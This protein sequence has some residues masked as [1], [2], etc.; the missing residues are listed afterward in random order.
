MSTNTNT[1][2]AAGDKRP[3]ELRCQ[4]ASRTA[5]VDA[6]K[7][8][9]LQQNKSLQQDTTRSG[10]DSVVLGCT[11]RLGKNSNGTCPVF[12][13]ISQSKVSNS[14]YVYEK[15]F[16]MEHI[17][18]NGTQK[19]SKKILSENHAVN[20][21]VN[22]NKNIGAKELQAHIH[23]HMQVTC[24]KSMAYRARNKIKS[25]SEAE[26][27]EKYLLLEPW[28]TKFMELNPK[29]AC[30]VEWNNDKEFHRLFFMNHAASTIM[31]H[32]A[33]PVSMT[34]CA[35]MKADYYNGQFMA[36]C[37]F[38]GNLN[39]RLI[40]A[41]L[42]PSESKENYIWFFDKISNCL[43]DEI[44]KKLKEEQH[45][46]YSDRDKGLTPAQEQAFPDTIKMF[47]F[48]HIY[49]NIQTVVGGCQHIEWRFWD[50][51]KSKSEAEFKDKMNDL[52]DVK[53]KAAEYLSNIPVED[54]ALY[55][56]INSGSSLYGHRTSNLIE[57]EN[58][59][60]L[61]VRSNEPYDFL[62][63]ICNITLRKNN[64]SREIVKKC[65]EKGLFMTEN[66]HKELSGFE[67][68][69]SN[70]SVTKINDTTVM[71]FNEVVEEMVEFK[72]SGG[73]CSCT[74]WQQ[75]KRPCD[76]A[77]AARGEY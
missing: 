59:T 8:I 4:F 28:S 12:I 2:S 36:M 10:R 46:H 20:V 77:I 7:R 44:P 5:A 30:S 54:W 75:C 74:Y 57:S 33:Q 68:D 72:K 16:N 52:E 3:L 37:M 35:F 63:G 62:V 58:S 1:D 47:C 39:I 51:Q 43:G 71:V 11:D 65:E 15:N 18:C 24:S 6:C 19:P 55:P 34:D 38:D 21:A 26:N 66:V 29:S 56:H 45:V 61:D 69:S 32:S 17:N 73:L 27:E 40:A 67:R 53:P 76:H 60:Y 9:A 31:E 49:G 25:I 23:G 13:R 70:L 42:V 64:E 22:A 41:A 50:I 48:K 14:W